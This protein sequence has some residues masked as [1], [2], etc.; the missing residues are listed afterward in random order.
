MRFLIEQLQ[1][2]SGSS[3]QEWEI[4]EVLRRLTGKDFGYNPTSSRTSRQ[5]AVHKW[6]TWF[7][8]GGEDGEESGSARVR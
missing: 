1:S 2:S 8:R 5:V 4:I 6:V 3:V 7:N